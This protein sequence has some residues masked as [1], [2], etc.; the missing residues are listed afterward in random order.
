MKN[1]S[2]EWIEWINNKLQH[3]QKT[4]QE[5]CAMMVQDVRL[6]VHIDFSISES[7]G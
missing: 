2:K 7:F 6:L 4:R 5:N 3:Q 1:E